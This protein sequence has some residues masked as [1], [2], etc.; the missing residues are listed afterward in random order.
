MEVEMHIFVF[1]IKKQRT[2]IIAVAVSEE[3]ISVTSTLK[4]E[5]ACSS[6][7]ATRCWNMWFVS[8]IQP[9]IMDQSPNSSKQ[10]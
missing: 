9:K 3:R 7:S 6:D 10:L 5:V 2:L 8:L 4:I 1:W